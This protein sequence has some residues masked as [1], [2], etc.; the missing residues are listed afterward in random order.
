MKTIEQNTEVGIIIA[1]FQSPELHEGHQDIINLV[2]VTHPRVIIFLGLSP[3]RCTKNNPYD[4]AIR[5]AMIEEKYK[6]VEILYIDDVG[7]DVVWS[8]SLDRLVAKN[9]GPGQKA[10][11]YGS[12]DSFIKSYSGKYPTVELVPNKIISASEIRRKIAIKPLTSSD[13]RKGIVYAVENQFPTIHPA[14]DC[15]IID[16]EK[17]MVLLGKKPGQIGLR[18][19]GGFLDPLTDTTA[20]AGTVREAKEETHLSLTVDKYLG[21]LLVNDW[22]YSHE[23]NKIMTFFYLLRYDNETSGRAE[24]GDDLEMVI[25]KEFGTVDLNDIVST[26]HPLMIL[27]DI[28]LGGKLLKK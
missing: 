28:N 3:L 13:F 25:W 21:S 12:R 10:T 5:K 11:L 6:D 16:F 9:I 15:A 26:H 17:E 23:Q 18:F 8:A 20:E 22:R 2:R 4:F 27:L 14:V 7:D 24:A 19:P 1:R